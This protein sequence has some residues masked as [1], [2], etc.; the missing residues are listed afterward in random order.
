M[1]KLLILILFVTTVTAQSEVSKISSMP[2]A[3]SRL[4]FGAR[5]MAM[6]NAMS[7]VTTGNKTAYYNPALASFQERNSFQSSYSFLSLDRSLNFVSITRNFNIGKK[8]EYEDGSAFQ[9][10]A[11]ISIGVINAGVDKIER[12]DNQ[13][14]K[15][16]DL[17]TSENQFFLGISN[18]FSDKLALGITFKL[19]YYS[20]YEEV[21]STSLGFDIGALYL[22]NDNITIALKLTDLN[23]KYEWDSTELYGSGGTNTE[24]KFPI[25]KTIGVSYEFDNYDLILAA[26]LES[27]NAESNIIRFG[28]EYNIYEGL[29]LRS[30]LDKLNISNTDDPVRPTFGFSYFY[31]LKPVTVGFDYAYV[32]EPYSSHDQHIIGLNINF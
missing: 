16:E 24:E 32:I 13:G 31:P 19:Y 29:Y 6:G 2:G 12:R 27:S 4:G 22:L 3:F 1:R 5:G 9:P 20:L 30:G 28:A 21:S 26:E 18:R 25:L 15:I 8:R 10:T 14:T 17:S 7:A 23:S 11:G